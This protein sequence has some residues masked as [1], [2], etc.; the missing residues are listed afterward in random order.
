[1]CIYVCW[2]NCHVRV[3]FSCF[4][5]FLLCISLSFSRR[6]SSEPFENSRQAFSPCA[7]ADLAISSVR[8][9][10]ACSAFKSAASRRTVARINSEP[11]AGAVDGKDVT[12]TR[13]PTHVKVSSPLLYESLPKTSSPLYVAPAI[14]KSASAIVATEPKTLKTDVRYTAYP[15]YSFNYGVIDGHTGDS[16]S[17]WEERD[18]D[19]VKGEYSVVE[20]DG[21][22]R[23]VSYT[24]D[25]R[26]GFN[27]VVTRSEPPKNAKSAVQVKTFVPLAIFARNRHTI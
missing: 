7:S 22:I 25:D 12:S 24:A 3:S 2:K 9:A 27:A 26:N 19:M 5:I 11:D 6:Y 14:V 13:R 20:A 4:Q 18:G 17:A 10:V 16:K 21:T 15:K 8:R 1:M 23:T